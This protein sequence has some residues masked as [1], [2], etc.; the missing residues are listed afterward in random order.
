[1]LGMGILLHRESGS[2]G[3]FSSIVTFTGTPGH[4]TLVAQVSMQHTGTPSTGLADEV[5]QNNCC[6]RVLCPSGHSP[7]LQ[8]AGLE[9]CSAPGSSAGLFATLTE[10]VC[11]QRP[12]CLNKHRIR[13]TI[14]LGEHLC[15]LSYFI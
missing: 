12:L 6:A 13:E 14:T 2:W 4:I 7:W 15:T 10:H 11:P 5:L 8:A 1:V 3:L 9:L